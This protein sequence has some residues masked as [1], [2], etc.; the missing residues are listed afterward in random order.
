MAAS[1]ARLP[2]M[3]VTNDLE[4]HCLDR[5]GR[6][7]RLSTTFDY[8]P[9][10]PW[11]VRLVFHGPTSDIDWLV[12]RDV[13]LDGLRGPA[14]DGDVRCWPDW[15]TAGRPAVALEFRSPG[16]RLV[17]RVQRQELERFLVR[18]LAEVPVGEESVDLDQLAADLLDEGWDEL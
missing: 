12:A 1:E 8:D 18:T 5:R 6:S 14:G 17:T 3:S 13:L 10:D 7:T 2:C 11:A 16:G 9:E 15:D 4:L